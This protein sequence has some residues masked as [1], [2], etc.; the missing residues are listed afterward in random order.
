MCLGIPGRIVQLIDGVEQRAI[1]EV[2]GGLRREISMAVIGTEPP[3]GAGEG[4]WVLIH[5]GF[6][7]ARLDE[8]EAASTIETLRLFGSAYEDELTDFASRFSDEPDDLAGDGEIPVA[9][10]ELAAEGGSP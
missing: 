6:A 8:E 10:A 5:V 7:M 3:D 9:E 4:D 1:V 2:E